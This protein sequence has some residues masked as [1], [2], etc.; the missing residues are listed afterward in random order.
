M[1]VSLDE[2][3]RLKLEDAQNLGAFSYRAQRDSLLVS[4]EAVIFDGD[5]A[6][7]SEA[8][9]RQWPLLAG[10]VDWQA[11]LDGMV[12]FARSRGWVHPESGR[13]RAHI[14]RD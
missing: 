8:H 3:G 14:K 4:S 2:E 9:L 1:I 6:W 7:V 10:D 13:I 11:S 12:D 5:V